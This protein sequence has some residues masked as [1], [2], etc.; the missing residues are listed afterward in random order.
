MVSPSTK[1]CSKT[2]RI[3]NSYNCV[4]DVCGDAQKQDLFGMIWKFPYAV[5][6][7]HWGSKGTKR[8]KWYT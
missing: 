4:A 5:V 3:K 6:A 2:T 8:E 1:I 7:I